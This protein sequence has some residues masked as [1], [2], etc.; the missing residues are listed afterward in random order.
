[1]N[2]Q[3]SQIL[4]QKTGELS[5]NKGIDTKNVEKAINLIDSI[6]KET[7]KSIGKSLDAK[8]LALIEQLLES[9]K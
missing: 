1:M 4:S 3:D 9:M 5:K 6:D 7:L 8:Q 2:K